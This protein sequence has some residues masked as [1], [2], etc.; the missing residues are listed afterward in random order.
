VAAFLFLASCAKNIQNTEAVRQGVIDYL[1]QRSTEIG[2][3]MNS[4]DVKITSLS[5]EKDLARADVS[6]Q[7]KGVPVG[8]GMAMSYV[9]DRKGDKW[10]VRGRQSNPATPHGGGQALPGNQATPGDQLPSGHP[11]AGT[12]P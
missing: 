11:G 4:F 5:F 7:P 6:F 9:L 1:K 2:I 8:G 12:N 10:A 3:D